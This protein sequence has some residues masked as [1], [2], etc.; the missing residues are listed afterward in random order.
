MTAPRIDVLALPVVNLNGSSREALVE[1]R[2]DIQRAL[3]ET[4]AAL[5]RAWPH[6]RDYQTVGRDRLVRADAVFQAR[7][8]ALVALLDEIEAEAAAILD[9]P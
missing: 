5:Q 4:L 3:I 7:R 2:L 1:Q 8:D 6:G 9:G